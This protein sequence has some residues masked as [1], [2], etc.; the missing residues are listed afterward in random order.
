MEVLENY[1]ALEGKTIAFAHMAQFAEQ[2]TIAT[3]DGCLLMAKFDYNEDDEDLQDA[4]EIRVI[5]KQR[6]IG[7]LESDKGRYL[8]EEL[9]KR[10]LF[11]LKAFKERE[12]AK[13]DKRQA[14]WRAK[15]ELKEKEE[16]ERL[17]AKFED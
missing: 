8:R 1:D 12:K 6:V 5:Q 17:K 9:G 4:P 3:T 7:I 15:Q 10:N 2:I 16:Y 14:E 11:D 13:L